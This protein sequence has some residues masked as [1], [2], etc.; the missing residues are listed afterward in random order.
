MIL[1]ALYWPLPLGLSSHWSPSAYG[2]THAWS[3]NHLLESLI[4]GQNPHSIS[5]L[6]YPWIREA[7]FIG[8]AP[9]IAS[10]PLNPLLGPVGAFQLVVF[11]SVG[12]SSVLAARLIQSITQ[13]APTQ[14]AMGGLLFALSP[15]QLSILQTGEAPKAQLW[16]I[17]LFL[18]AMKQ[19]MESG[20]RGPMAV[21]LAAF[22]ASFTSPYYGLALPLLA[23]II[24]LTLL[25][26]KQIR[27]GFTLVASTA[28]GLLPGWIYFRH[29]PEGIHSFFRPAL[30]PEDLTGQLPIPHPVASVSDLL[31]GNATSIETTM[32]THHQSYLGIF[33]LL[34]CAVAAWITRNQRITGRK[35][36]LGLFIFG[37]LLAMGPWLALHNSSVGVPLPAALLEALNYP[38]E[39]G[40]MYYR[41]VPFA[42][43]GLVVITIGCLEPQ[44][45]ASKWLAL[46]LVL[47]IS[48]SIRSTGPW[49]LPVEALPDYSE[50]QIEETE[51]GG[52]VLLVPIRASRDP[53]TAQRAVLRQLL[54]RRPEVSLPGDLKEAELHDLQGALNRA[55]QESDPST[56][57]R[58][59]GFRFVLYA[60]AV[61]LAEHRIERD[62]LQRALGTPTRL[63]EGLLW[64][65]GET[66]PQPELITDKLRH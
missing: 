65:L 21:A 17:P 1:G 11:L 38:L 3:A 41:M 2:A 6:G 56:A 28:I 53:Q 39:A 23:G 13:C 45:H 59:Q 57:L 9:A 61:A 32:A 42:V 24:A 51:P 43:L 50:L 47:Q 40:G 33:L 19:C 20:K 60:P 15:Y 54:H 63:Q 36:G 64:D 58:V 14:A 25:P 55:L 26:S 62:R 52:A 5:D 37:A 35:A 4:A 66:S 27:R 7:R 22:I 48:D 34:G 49:P 8:W 46:L 30:A 18:I 31:F 29:H 44:Q 12:L 16:V 10:W